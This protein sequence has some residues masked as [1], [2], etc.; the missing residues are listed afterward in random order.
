MMVDNFVTQNNKNNNQNRKTNKS[1]KTPNKIQEGMTKRQLEINVDDEDDAG[2]AGGLV[3]T[4]RNN[5]NNNPQ[6]ID[7]TKNNN[8]Y[9]T[10]CQNS[11]VM[12]KQDYNML[13]PHSPYIPHE[14][15]SQFDDNKST[16]SRI[17]KI[18]KYTNNLLNKSNNV[19]ND[20]WYQFLYNYDDQI[21][22]DDDDDSVSLANKSQG[23]ISRFTLNSKLSNTARSN[24]SKISKLQN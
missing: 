20:Q 11:R 14:R 1:S 24:M 12:K 8:K 7:S 2:K 17:S 13:S 10:E 21:L 15:A 16:Y 9:Y 18:S 23:N 22:N 4:P 3:R 19:I 5:A 6:Q